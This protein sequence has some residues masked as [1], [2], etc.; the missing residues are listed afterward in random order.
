[1]STIAQFAIEYS[2]F[3]DEHGHLTQPLPDFAQVPLH[4]CK[5]YRLMTLIRT[6]DAKAITLQRTGKL[7][8][9][10]SMLGQEAISVAIGAA[11]QEQDVLCPYYRDV[12]AQIQ[13]GV[14]LSEILAFWSGDERSNYYQNNTDDFPLCVPIGTQC[15]HAVG[16]A[17]ALK[18]RK[19][20]RVVV[21]VCGDGATSQGD[22]YEAINVA[23]V[24]NLPIVFVINNNQWAISVPRQNQTAA[25]TLAQ[26]AIAAGFPGEQVDGNDVIAVQQAVLL[27]LAKARAGSGPTLIEALSYRLHD[28]TTADDA[29]RYRDKAEVDLAWQ[30]EPLL[31]LRRYLQSNNLW[32]APQEQNLTMECRQLVDQAVTEYFALIPEAPTAMIDY[33]YA[34]LPVALQEQRETIRKFAA[35]VGNHHD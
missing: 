34:E 11:M 18:Y 29:T 23:G 24:W 10:P 25:Q 32:S 17:T 5:L 2:Q 28:H 9:Y 21:C 16:V 14:T 31:R 3:L 15:L 35:I 13:R 33:L 6:F 8:T 22:F 30:K 4:L 26:K 27:A 1:M 12:G 20:P 7:N 19:Q